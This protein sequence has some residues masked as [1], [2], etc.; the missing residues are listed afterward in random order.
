MQCP[1]G[2]IDDQYEIQQP[3]ATINILDAQ[4]SNIV[5][6]KQIRLTGSSLEYQNPDN[7][8]RDADSTSPATKYFKPLA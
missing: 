4:V 7:R 8:L 3:P 5:K 1:T 2:K 6:S